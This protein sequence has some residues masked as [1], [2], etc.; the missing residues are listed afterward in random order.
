MSTRTYGVL[1][2]ILAGC[3]GTIGDM[4]GEE[5]TPPIELSEECDPSVAPDA[6]LLRIDR[7][8]YE[9][10]LRSL[11]GDVNVDAVASAVA[12][13][14]NT[15]LGQYRSEVEAP[16]FA[17]VESYVDVASSMAFYLTE[18]PARLSGIS[19]C[20]PTLS[21]P[22]DA[23]GEACLSG[24]IDDFGLRLTRRPLSPE[25]HTRFVEAY[26][27]G[28]AEDAQTGVATM[29]LSMLLDPR[30]LYH[31][32]IDGEESQPGVIAL[33]SYE[34]AAR[35]ARVLWKS[36]PDDGL[37]AAA[38]EGFEGDEGE[39]RLR[40]EIERMWATPAAREGFRGFA[41]EWIA[42]R[43]EGP[44][45]DAL[46]EFATSIVYE[47]EGSLADLFLDRTAFIENDEL[48]EVYGLP[49]DTRGEVQLNPDQRAGLLTR[50][51]W[52][53]TRASNNTNAGHI[54]HRGKDL[55]ELL[56]VPIP[57]PADDV[58]PDEDPTEPTEGLRTMRQRL[59]DVTSEEPCSSCHVRL[60]ALG[61][62]FG[63]FD[64]QGAYIEEEL[65]LLD[66]TEH[67]LDID[68][69]ASINVG[70]GTHVEVNSAL[71]VSV[72]AAESEAVAACLGAELTESMMGRR[73]LPADACIV[74]A[75]R[76][77]LSP[78]G[79]TS[80]REALFAIVTSPSF[81]VRSIPEA[82]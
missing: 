8:A 5:T 44:A 72:A 11:F 52:L 20:L 48:A 12:G 79:S 74:Q 21:E 41:Q 14:P 75:A 77:Q 15:R 80:V 60:D 81:T 34:I 40:D 53:T 42:L 24:F 32:E 22:R 66:D 55:S 73:V 9:S 68:S 71:E 37:L 39:A 67:I 7:R 38:A 16:S 43:H 54:I 25:D 6:E 1:V 19:E 58:F 3:Q 59:M 46:L 78:T 18:Q 64:A 63:H 57:L 28:A 69:S 17:V 51:G 4:P 47:R 49:A 23:A 13:V 82:Q 26:E 30:F 29:L 45:S 61:A 56:C 36:V 70:E 50:A 35:L 31:F 33:T 62:P 27:I 65:A 10:A 2:L 76:D